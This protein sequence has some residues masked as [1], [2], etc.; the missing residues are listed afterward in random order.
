MA[1]ALRSIPVTERFAGAPTYNHPLLLNGRKMVLGYP[2][3]VNS[4]GLAWE[5]P[6]A[7]L[8]ASS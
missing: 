7:K 8:D 3:H 5:E 1:D 4:H 6:S 2:G